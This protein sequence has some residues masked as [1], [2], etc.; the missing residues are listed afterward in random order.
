MVVDEAAGATLDEELAGGFDTVLE[1][2][3]DAADTG[4]VLEAGAFVA[5]TDAEPVTA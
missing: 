4:V 5:E 2:V 1:L 3:D